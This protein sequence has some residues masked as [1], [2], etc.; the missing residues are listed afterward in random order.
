M[1]GL[2]GNLAWRARCET[3]KEKLE[4]VVDGTSITV[5][6]PGTDFSLTYQKRLGNPHLILTRSWVA[7]R[8]ELPRH[9]RVSGPGF[10]GCCRQG[11]RIGLDYLKRDT[12]GHSLGCRIRDNISALVSQAT[13][14]I[15]SHNTSPNSAPSL[16]G[17]FVCVAVVIPNSGLASFHPA[18]DARG[19]VIP[20]RSDPARFPQNGT[21]EAP[22]PPSG[23]SSFINSRLRSAGPQPESFRVPSSE[24]TRARNSNGRRTLGSASTD[25]PRQSARRVYPKALPR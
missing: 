10:S 4:L 1:R 11:A 19:P 18:Y 22:L 13:N 17:L 24:E 16:A 7:A 9:I 15:A 6:K 8:V 20:P 3:P 21:P 2:V 14:L 25:I 5:T 23:A 12:R